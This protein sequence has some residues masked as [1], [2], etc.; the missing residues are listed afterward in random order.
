[1]KLYLLDVL[2]FGHSDSSTSE[3]EVVLPQSFA[4]LSKTVCGERRTGIV[5]GRC[6]NNYTVHFHSP[7][8]LCKPT[9]PAGCKLGWFFYILSEVVPITVVFIVVLVFNISFTSGAVN[10][11]ILF[12]QLLAS[13]DIYAGGITVFSESEQN[14]FNAVTQGY[15]IV[16]GFLNLDFFNAESLSFCLW[17]GASALDMLAFKFFTILYTMLLIVVV[18][19]VM[20]KCGGRCLGK[21][22]RITAIKIS[23]IHGIS[24]FLVICYAQC[25]K[26][27]LS[28]LLPV[29]LSYRA[30]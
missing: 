3:F 15:Q 6:Q 29:H 18:I 13:L 25:V 5:C 17:K 21:Y 9:E 14:I 7:G 28:L 16:Y 8:F 30:E 12:S 19:W 24:T 20:N 1:M 4:E 27:S 23:L 10:G 22:C 26:I 2:L 11:F